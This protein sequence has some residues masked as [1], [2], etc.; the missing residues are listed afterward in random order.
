[1]TL[2]LIID[3]LSI[4]KIQSNK[5]GSFQK[6][7]EAVDLLIV[8]KMAAVEKNEEEEEEQDLPDFDDEAKDKLSKVVSTLRRGSVLAK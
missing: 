2:R 5:N 1:M 6:D 4:V 7:S 8:E 3:T